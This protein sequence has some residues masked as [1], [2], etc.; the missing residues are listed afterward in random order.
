MENMPLLI[1]TKSRKNMEDNKTKKVNRQSQ[2]NKHQQAQS[3]QP[4]PKQAE[5]QQNEQLEQQ[6]AT[7]VTENNN[8]KPTPQDTEPKKTS[9]HSIRSAE[10]TM[11]MFIMP[12][13]VGHKKSS[14]E[15]LTY[16]LVDSMS[17]RAFISEELVNKLDISPSDITKQSMVLHTLNQHTEVTNRQ[18]QGLKLRGY[19]EQYTINLPT[20][21]TTT[22]EI[23]INK[24]H[25]PTKEAA[26]RWKHLRPISNRLPPP[27]NIDVG[28]LL[29]ANVNA[30]HTPLEVITNTPE[31]PFAKRTVLGWSITGN[32]Q[33][34]ANQTNNC[35][36]H[37]MITKEVQDDN[38]LRKEVVFTPDPSVPTPQQI[39]NILESDFQTT[40]ES[41][42]LS[43]DDRLF[44]ATL[45]KETYQDEKTGH[46]T[47]P[48]PFK[49]NPEA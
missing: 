24:S 40:N 23:P 25:I 38:L 44:M 34:N 9:C 19:K 26:Q 47:M 4:Q 10:E 27:M 32:H 18:I 17:D 2:A 5:Q 14:I 43:V 8:A 12:V 39:L 15:L 13:Y 7:K 3:N 36:T 48:L 1:T 16:A 22:N 37:R 49:K 42:G 6:K 46:L 11:S 41:T 21:T 30:A 28:I 31:E 35:F 45:T 20:M 33:A 29:G